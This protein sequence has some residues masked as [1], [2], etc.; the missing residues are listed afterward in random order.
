M[1]TPVTDKTACRTTAC[2]DELEGPS[3]PPRPEFDFP[4]DS[5][6]DKNYCDGCS[7]DYCDD[8]LEGLRELASV[9]EQEQVEAERELRWVQERNTYLEDDN[10]GL[11]RELA[12][13]DGMIASASK[14][15]SKMLNVHCRA[16]RAAS[17]RVLTNDDANRDRLCKHLEHLDLDYGY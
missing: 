10:L 6:S 3:P 9:A 8:Y 1:A 15:M 4:A 17:T 12:I 5:P 14:I 2:T 13:R 7:C 11:R 16:A